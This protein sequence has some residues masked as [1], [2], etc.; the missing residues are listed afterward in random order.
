M[1]RGILEAL[2]AVAASAAVLVGCQAESPTAGDADAAP[3][4]LAASEAT[5]AAQASAA[6]TDLAT[7]RR[8]TARYHSFERAQADG[9]TAKLTECMAS[10]EGGMGYHYGHPSLI[11]GGVDV[12]APEVLL[13]EP[14]RNGQL[15]LVGVEYVVPFDA[16][17]APESP[18]LFGQHFHRNDSFEL[19]ALHVWVWR[20]NPSGLFADWNPNVSCTDAR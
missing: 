18:V 20:H 1:R 2:A 7:L 5:R 10:A 15:R 12:A 14:Q 16:W 8:V 4:S 3:E 9:Y 11:D 6:S 13:Y 19:W 17:R